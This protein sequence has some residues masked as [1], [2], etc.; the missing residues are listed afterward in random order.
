MEIGSVLTLLFC[1]ACSVKCH[2]LTGTGESAP[3]PDSSIHISAP[4]DL[5]EDETFR[6]WWNLETNVPIYL[7]FIMAP[8]LNFKSATFF[9]KF[10]SI[11]KSQFSYFKSNCTF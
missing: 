6:W 4:N 8:L 10:N 5:Q 11:G 7:I 2:L 3:S 1:S 9:T